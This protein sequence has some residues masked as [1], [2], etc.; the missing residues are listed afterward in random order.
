MASE[1]EICNGA[2]QKLGSA[3]IQSLTDQSVNA[4]ACALAYYRLRDAELAAHPW[5]FA[6]QRFQ[7]AQSATIPPF[8]NKFYY[9]L[10]VGWLRLLPPDALWNFN[11]RDWIIEGNNVLTSW[12]TPL[13]VRLVMKVED[14]NLMHVLFRES[15]SCRIANEICEA[16]TQSNTKKQAASA[17]YKD[18]IA[19]AKKTNAI[20]KVPQTAV[21]DVW[22]T[23]RF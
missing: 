14:P 1:T 20:M 22:I 13:N 9:P 18:T 7:I 8:G 4:R 2:L 15:L 6:I 19:E 5:N 3:R 12:G 23:A 21:E 11:D 16:L 17:T 10:P